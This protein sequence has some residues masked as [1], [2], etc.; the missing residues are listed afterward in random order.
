MTQSAPLIHAT[1]TSDSLAQLKDL[2]GLDG[3]GMFFFFRDGPTGA[4]GGGGAAPKGG[5]PGGGG[6]P[7]GGGGGGGGIRALPGGGGGGGGIMPPGG[8]G[9]GGGGKRG[10]GGPGMGGPPEHWLLVSRNTKGMNSGWSLLMFAF[11][12]RMSTCF[13]IIIIINICDALTYRAEVMYS[14]SHFRHLLLD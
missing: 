10:H 4:P 14:G 3:W 1:L 11:V 9:G 6:G 5:R 12:K 7:P 2:S 13:C 8:G